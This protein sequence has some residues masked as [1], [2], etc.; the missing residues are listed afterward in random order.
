MVTIYDNLTQRNMAVD[1]PGLFIDPVDNT[2]TFLLY[3]LSGQLVGY[4]RYNPNGTKEKRNSDSGRYYTYAVKE[5]DKTRYNAVWGIETLQLNTPFVFIC[6]GIFDANRI[7]LAGYPALAILSNDSR[8]L[9]GFL[10]AF[11][12]PV[13]A[14][15]DDDKAGQ[16]SRKM[17]NFAYTVPSPY[18][19]LDEMPQSEVQSFLDEI[20]Q[21][22]GLRV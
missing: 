17:A 12:R 16:A 18:H 13:I 14:I 5:G 21:K 19:D 8:S 10:A 3:N 11:N 15:M 4:Q 2:A 22:T 20:L 9:R 7:H 1:R 6:E